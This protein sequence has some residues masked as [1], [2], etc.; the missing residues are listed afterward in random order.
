MERHFSFV[1]LALSFLGGGYVKAE[2]PLESHG[3][4]AFP[5]VFIKLPGQIEEGE[6][7]VA[8]LEELRAREEEVITRYSTEPQNDG[9]TTA[10][11]T[12]GDPKYPCDGPGATTTTGG[13]PKYP[14]DGPAAVTSA[15]T[16]S[17]LTYDQA[18]AR[19]PRASQ[20][21]HI[22][23]NDPDFLNI[24]YRK[25]E[26]LYEW[27]EKV[28]DFWVQR[29]DDHLQKDICLDLDLE[30]GECLDTFQVGSLA[31]ADSTLR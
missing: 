12:G 3:R 27:D 18:V 2:I 26:H 11:A 20:S 19:Y 31:N 22:E 5:N 1:L 25:E 6:E 15:T 21:P 10:T 7:N 16:S 29:V 24:L 14:C 13:D 30:S 8:T 17:T 9:S 28:R 23:W 4:K